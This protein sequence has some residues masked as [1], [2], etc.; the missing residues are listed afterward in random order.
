MPS[1]EPEAPA[2]VATPAAPTGPV[3]TACG[4]EAVVN[5]RRRPTDDEHAA[6]I[7]LEQ[8]RRNERLLLADPQQPAPTFP[9]LPTAHDTTITVYACPGH[10]ISMEAASRIH[11]AHCTAPNGQPADGTNPVECDCTPEPPP[12]PAPDPVEDDGQAA[13]RLP[14]HWVTGGA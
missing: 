2:P 12:A 4:T 1:T 13:S 3:C 14:A 9:P 8:E 10:A 5:W 7:T 11:Q 6:H